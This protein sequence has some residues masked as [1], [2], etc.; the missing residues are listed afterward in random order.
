MI[1]FLFK[2]F[3][4]F[5]FTFNVFGTPIEVI[6]IGQ[7]SVNELKTLMHGDQIYCSTI[8]LSRILKCQLYHSEE[9]GKTVI[10]IENS[11]IKVSAQS[12]F[13]FVDNHAYQTPFP[14][15]SQKTDIYL[16]A[17]G[18]FNILKS[19]VFPGLN[20]YSHILV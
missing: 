17:F 9:R 15:L 16:P 5:L 6:N 2:L 13:V 19:S 8:D 18:F 1:L 10:Y 4:I 3:L 11:R 14:A 7:N 12:S 20:A